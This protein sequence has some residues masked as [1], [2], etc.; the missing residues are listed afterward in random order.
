MLGI[1][2]Q[3]KSSFNLTLSWQSTPSTGLVLMT[4][5]IATPLMT[6]S[7]FSNGIGRSPSSTFIGRLIGWRTCSLTSVIASPSAPFFF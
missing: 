3:K 2:V 5:V 6:S 7:K 4:C 1:W